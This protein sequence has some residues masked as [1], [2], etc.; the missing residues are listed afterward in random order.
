MGKFSDMDKLLKKF[1][2]NTLPG[3]ACVI[4]K[5]GETI[6]EGYAGYAD[7]DKKVPVGEHSIFR[8]AS[9]TK[10]F[11]YA[12]CMMLFEQGEFLLNEPLYEYLP[13]WRNTTKFVT[14]PNGE[15]VVEPVKNPI[16]IRDAL[17][18][19]CGL[20]YCMAPLRRKSTNPTLNAMSEAMEPLT[21]NGRIPTLRE[22]SKAISQVPIMFEPGTHWQYGFGSEIVGCLVEA[23]TGKSV[24][25]NMREKIIWPL[26]MKDTETLLDAEMAKRL[27]GN[28]RCTPDGKLEKMP[29]E[30]DATIMEGG[31][32]DFARA[33]L[34]TSA[35]DF[36]I[37]MSML[38]NGGMYNGERYLGRKTIDL[39]RTNHLNDDQLKD[40][41]NSY[42]AGYGYG[43]GVRT[44]MSKAAAGSNGSL[45][46]FG[47]TGGAGTW[48][49]IDPSEGVSI[50]YMHNQSPNEEEY[51]HLRVR[52]VAYGCID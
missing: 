12:I 19:S 22:E 35:K 39:M 32:P 44:L 23:I 16:T 7:I 30:M 29:P 24:R 41:T 11:T 36:A 3:C 9:T 34:N 37:F 13:E 51:H 2:D 5:N 31:V 47:W 6:Y 46:A 10:L 50:V 27:V 21:A 26:G 33:A 8:Q 28:Y 18:M 49:E 4:M 48:C 1:A 17:T 38:A 14:L 40:F 43:L 52:N 15:V 25:Q 42:L 20:P 45:G